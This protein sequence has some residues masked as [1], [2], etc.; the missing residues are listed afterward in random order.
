MIENPEYLEK[1]Q[2]KYKQ[3]IANSLLNDV[4]QSLMNGDSYQ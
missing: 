1:I 4:I 2:V 3:I